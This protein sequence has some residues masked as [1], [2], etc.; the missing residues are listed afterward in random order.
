MNPAVVE[1]RTPTSEDKSSKDC[2]VDEMELESSTSDWSI[3]SV[4]EV[5][6]SPV[7][8]ARAFMLFDKTLSDSPR[9]SVPLPQMSPATVKVPAMFSFPIRP[10]LP[11]ASTVI[12]GEVVP[13]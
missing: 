10:T 4:F 6:E 9:H 13:A 7:V 1:A 11:S 2:V 8:E 3:V 12:A 5:M